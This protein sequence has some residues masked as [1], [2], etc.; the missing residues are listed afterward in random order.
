MKTLMGTLLRHLLPINFY[1]GIK[2][3]EDE[4]EASTV[5]NDNFFSL[6]NREK[7]ALSIVKLRM[8]NA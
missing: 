7:S 2:K 3:L 4:Y 5:L 1:T 8:E 6:K